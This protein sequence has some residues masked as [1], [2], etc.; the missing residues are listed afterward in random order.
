PRRAC[1][2]LR[3]SR[4]AE[5]GTGIVSQFESQ[6]SYSPHHNLKFV[7]SRLVNDPAFRPLLTHAC[8]LTDTF[9]SLAFATDRMTA[10]HIGCAR[11]AGE[12]LEK[13]PVVTRT[14]GN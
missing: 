7:A 6:C 2:R 4:K 1:R 10:R 3:E 9:A 14:G 8:D 12:G 11:R 13:S 5:A